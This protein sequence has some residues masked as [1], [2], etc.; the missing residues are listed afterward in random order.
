LPPVQR[1]AD[2]LVHEVFADDIAVP[3]P[4]DWEAV[5]RERHRLGAHTPLSAV[6][7]VAAESEVRRLVLTHFL[8][9]DDTLA[10]E[11]WVRGAAASFD[12]EVI[13]G[14]DLLELKL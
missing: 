10:D 1:G 6:G 12:G 2:I 4:A 11:H 8:P 3:E 5:Q 13:P 9:G 7:R 14:S